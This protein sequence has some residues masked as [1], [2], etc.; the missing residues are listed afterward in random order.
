MTG[1]LQR[2]S[3]S[4]IQWVKSRPIEMQRSVDEWVGLKYLDAPRSTEVTETVMAKRIAMIST[5]L[6]AQRVGCVAVGR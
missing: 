6:G 4:A 1:V 2:V 5:T 3:E